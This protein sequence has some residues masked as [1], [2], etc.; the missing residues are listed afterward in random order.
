MT[1][2]DLGGGNDLYDGRGGTVSGVVTGGLGDDLFIIDSKIA[3]VENVGE[4]TD[5]IKSTISMNF[6]AGVLAGQELEN[7]TLLGTKKLNATG[8]ALDNTIIGNRGNNHLSG[9]SGDDI[10]TGGKGADIFI[11][12]N[13]SDKDT[14]TD[15]GL[16]ADRVDLSNLSPVTS[17]ADLMVHHISKSG[18]DLV[19]HSGWDRLI[20]D[21]TSKSD[22]H[23]Y[24]FIF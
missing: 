12:K 21:H 20:L 17:F 5:T 23:V 2:L 9:E 4:G 11:F 6:S 15:F 10:L 22:L 7:L 14:I 24:D 1:D 8:N 16:G 18:A 19:I 3:I 13:G